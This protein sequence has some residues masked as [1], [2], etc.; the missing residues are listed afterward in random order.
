MR[1]VKL[2]AT[3]ERVFLA[4]YQEWGVAFLFD[5]RQSIDKQLAT[6]KKVLRAQ[7]AQDKKYGLL[8]LP[9]T[10][11]NRN[12]DYRA[13][14]RVLDGLDTGAIPS[15]IAAKLFPGRKA[16]RDLVKALRSEA[17]RLRDGGYRYMTI[18]RATGK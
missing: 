9:R 5:L 1:D 15:T 14:L 17:E 6:A 13:M 16:A 11:R 3:G 4:R 12:P 18:L 7:V 10:Q 8:P 2:L